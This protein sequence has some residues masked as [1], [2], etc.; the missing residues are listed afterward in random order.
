MSETASYILLLLVFVLG[1]LC[2]WAIHCIS[3]LGK[4]LVP[5]WRIEPRCFGTRFSRAAANDPN[6]DCRSCPVSARC[7]LQSYY[8]PRKPKS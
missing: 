6:R 2:G 1:T 4:R 5:R 7:S 8:N 3:L